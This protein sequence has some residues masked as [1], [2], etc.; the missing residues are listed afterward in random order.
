[1]RYLQR[2]D[3]VRVGPGLQAHQVHVTF[4]RAGCSCSYLGRLA[5]KEM[6]ASGG[7]ERENVC[8]GRLARWKEG[9]RTLETTSL[10]ILRK[11]AK[12][13]ISIENR[14]FT[15]PLPHVSDVARL[16]HPFSS[17]RHHLTRPFVF[18]ISSRDRPA[19]R[20]PIR[21]HQQLEPALSISKPSI[22]IHQRARATP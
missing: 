20:S 12:P 9:P 15:A 22:T 8:F 18:F 10:S 17:H 14:L 1:M 13:S 6:A 7:R 21:I 16:I 5:R 3:T 19:H 11:V 2:V 4:A